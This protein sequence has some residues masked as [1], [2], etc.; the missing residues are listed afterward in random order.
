MKALST[1]V[2]LYNFGRKLL[3][4]L[5]MTLGFKIHILS[6]QSNKCMK[7]IRNMYNRQNNVLALREFPFSLKNTVGL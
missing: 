2:K 7:L 3:G 1:F 5:S 4:K 6:K